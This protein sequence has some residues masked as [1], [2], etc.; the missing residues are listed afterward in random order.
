[1]SKSRSGSSNKES[2]SPPLG[3]SPRDSEV[4]TED[5]YVARTPDVKEEAA[6][7]VEESMTPPLAPDVKPVR[8]GPQLIGDL[9]RAEEEALRTFIELPSNH[10]QY[11]TLGRSREA[12]E[13][14]TC[15][16]QYEHGQ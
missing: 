14:M 3:L 6:P 1:M 10:Y 9:P 2:E 15:D 8:K 16:C 13:S 5:T 12:L 4:K 7:I 11:G